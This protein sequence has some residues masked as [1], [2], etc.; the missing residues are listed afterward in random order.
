MVQRGHKRIHQAHSCEEVG[1]RKD[2]EGGRPAAD[3]TAGY[4]VYLSDFAD[5]RAGSDSRKY[6]SHHLYHSK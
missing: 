2:L 5:T 6:Y 4:T 1:W 3:Y